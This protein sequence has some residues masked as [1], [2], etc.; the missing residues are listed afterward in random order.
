M[1]DAIEGIKEERSSEKV[2]KESQN[3][4]FV[5]VESAKKRKEFKWTE[6]RLEGFNK[7]RKALEEK[8]IIT[9]QLKAEKAKSEKDE[10]KRRVK[11]IMQKQQEGAEEQVGVESKSKKKSKI[12]LSSSESESSSEEDQRHKKKVP[13]HSAKAK[14][15]VV[16]LK[17]E[18]KK[19][20]RAVEVESDSSN[21]SSEES[22]NS[23]DDKEE[24]AVL[25]ARQRHDYEKG[26]RNVGKTPK[27]STYVNAM[28]QF[29]LL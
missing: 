29:I 10:I 12:V 24:R 16:P 7:M 15:E 22:D 4:D 20:K 11:A 23:E 19:K 2:E 8:N 5:S 27:Q 14:K 13:T 26:K 18:K 21:S 6:K 1:A 17:N 3:N 9:K 28:D 25:S